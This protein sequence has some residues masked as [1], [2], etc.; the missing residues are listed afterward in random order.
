M[1][2]QCNFI[3]RL[4]KDPIKRVTPT[5]TVVTNFSIALDESYKDKNGEKVEK[6]EWVNITAFARLGEICAEFLHKGSL[7]FISGKIQTSKYQDTDGK[8]K[9]STSIVADQMRM[10][11]SK[12][13]LSD[14]K[15]SGVKEPASF[16]DFKSDI[17]F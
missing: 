2:N 17:P 5:N 12:T 6:V 1:L 15:E 14:K 10:L 13:E 11:S 16:E 8:D 9:Y 7:V 3:G 4:G